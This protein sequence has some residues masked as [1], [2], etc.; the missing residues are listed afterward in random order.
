MARH[1]E[2]VSRGENLR[3]STKYLQG[4]ATRPLPFT[5]NNITTYDHMVI[6]DITVIILIDV[7]EL[8]GTITTTHHPI[9][10]YHLEH[11]PSNF[12]T[13]QCRGS[14]ETLQSCSVVGSR[15]ITTELT[16]FIVMLGHQ[17]WVQPFPRILFGCI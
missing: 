1:T 7:S 6:Q 16:C 4:L 8:I 3:F 14:S 15:L 11:R 9:G 2:H 12:R 10:L 13:I 17:V 5:V